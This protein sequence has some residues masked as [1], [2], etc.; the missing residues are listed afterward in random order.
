[1]PVFLVEDETGLE[2]AT[3]YVAL[4][5]A[6]DYLGDAWATDDTAKQ[7]ALMSASEYAD[8]RWG[9]K[10]KGGLLEDNQG[11][12]FPRTYLYDRYG[13]LIEGVPDDWKKAICLYAQASVAGTLYP[14]PTTDTAKEVKREKTVVG[15]ITKEREYVGSATSASWLK[16]PLADKLA[17]QYTSGSGGVVRA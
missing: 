13:T 12:E 16:F 2:D 10:L 11:L 3:S 9:A 6:N 17:R 14:T 5:F 15:P 8:V 7:N 4:S 1:M